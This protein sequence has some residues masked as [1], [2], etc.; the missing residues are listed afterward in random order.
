MWLFIAL[1]LIVAGAALAA[2]LQL[3]SSWRGER[4]DGPRPY[5]LQVARNKGKAH[6][7]FIGVDAP[8]SLHFTLKP[9]TGFDR[10]AKAVGL[11]EEFQTGDVSFDDTV[12]LLSDDPRVGQLFRRDTAARAVALRLLGQTAPD[13][14]AQRLRCVHG[15]L[16]LAQ[17]VSSEDGV[18]SAGLLAPQT[19]ADLGKLVDGLAKEIARDGRWQWRDAFVLRS[20]LALAVGIGLLVNG[21]VE[22][23]RVL[24]VRF[25]FHENP[26]QPLQLALVASAI[27]TAALIGATALWLGRSA[28][29]HLVVLQLLLICGAGSLAS[30]YCALLDANVEL[31]YS[32]AEPLDAQVEGKHELRGRRSRSYYLTLT[33]WHED[34]GTRVV[35]V[36]FPTWSRTPV[37]APVRVYTHAGRF[38]WPWVERLGLGNDAR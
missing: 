18:A 37:G 20:A 26:R 35:Q 21:M 27:V 38:G 32:P 16:W 33:D 13:L 5:W 7:Y 28:R 22:G 34:H 11:A 29:R 36:D 31:D 3:R 25:P 14:K 6:T 10:L 24:A 30:V 17:R 19:V 9:E 8:E 2:W 12:Y 23:L 1:L 4:I 15:R